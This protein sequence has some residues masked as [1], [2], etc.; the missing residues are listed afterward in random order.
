M[1]TYNSSDK[2]ESYLY[3]RVY[4]ILSVSNED[5]ERC[6][7]SYGRETTFKILAKLITDH[8]DF[9]YARARKPLVIPP[10]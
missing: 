2:I 7:E 6:V 10:K 9:P 1:T 3:P 5:L 4:P 8:Y